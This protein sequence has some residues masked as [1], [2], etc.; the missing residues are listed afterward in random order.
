PS[1]PV[2]FRDGAAKPWLAA[3]WLE[4]HPT[5]GALAK[6]VVTRLVLAVTGRPEALRLTLADV[7]APIGMAVPLSIRVAGLAARTVLLQPDGGPATITLDLPSAA[8]IGGA[9][10]VEFRAEA[11]ITPKRLGW[12]SDDATPLSF[13]LLSA[14]ALPGGGR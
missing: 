7:A 10:D 14:E 9:V 5:G 4:P 6:A 11:T 12:S 1:G 2:S 13:A 8:T 3:G